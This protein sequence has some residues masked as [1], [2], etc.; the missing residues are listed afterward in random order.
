VQKVNADIIVRPATVNDI[1]AIQSVVEVTWPIAY[2]EIVSSRQ[3]NYM[4][5]L[6]YSSSSLEE[7]MYLGRKFF[8]AE[9][10]QEII[11][12]AAYKEEAEHGV[13]KLDRLYVLPNKQQLGLG[14]TL[15]MKVV[16]SVIELGGKEIILQ[17][18]RK[19]KA[20]GFYKKMG[21]EIKQSIDFAIGEGFFMND[22]I[23]SL[24]L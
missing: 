13:Y 21:F 24:L 1:P 23:M 20:V 6:W 18:H 9:M 17:V 3:L 19:N 8:V 10:Q 15:L 12:F 2:S 11:G 14:K 4:I 22:Y 7:Q 16:S 5:N